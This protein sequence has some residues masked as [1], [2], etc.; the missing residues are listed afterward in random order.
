MSRFNHPIEGITPNP[1]PTDDTGNFTDRSFFIRDL[2]L[3]GRLVHQ[4]RDAAEDV[5]NGEVALGLLSVAVDTHDELYTISSRQ[6]NMN[7]IVSGISADLGSQTFSI[8]H[9]INRVDAIY[10]YVQRTHSLVEDLWV[11]PD[12]AKNLIRLVI[13]TDILLPLEEQGNLIK[14]AT[15]PKVFS[16]V[17]SC[18]ESLNL[19]LYKS[20]D[21]FVVERV[22]DFAERAYDKITSVVF[23]MV[24]GS[25]QGG[26]SVNTA[27]KLQDAL[28]AR[29]GLGRIIADQEKNAVLITFTHMQ[30]GRVLSPEDLE[31][32]YQVFADVGMFMDKTVTSIGTNLFSHEWRYLCSKHVTNDA[33]ATF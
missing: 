12:P 29:S 4:L 28:I 14:D 17:K 33:L 1:P 27:R 25:T 18:A 10:S 23:Q 11:V 6:S 22:N 26:R 19:S 20:G 24:L 31:L 7:A 15:L 16:K 32:Q 2:D 8:Q 5:P 21:P 13:W 30:D 9:V 3:D